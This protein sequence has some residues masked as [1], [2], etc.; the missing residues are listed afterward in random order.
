MTRHRRTA[1]LALVAGLVAGG[2][3]AGC[4]MPG[5]GEKELRYE[6]YQDAPQ[7][8]DRD[9]VPSSFIPTDAENLRIR[10]VTD[11]PGAI[12]GYESPSAPIGDDCRPASLADD[13]LLTARWW[14]DDV[15][16][17]GLICGDWQIFEQ[18]GTTF[19]FR[20]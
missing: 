14:P 1:V 2:T 9:L 16:A 6:V 19:A 7:R 20:R 8:G 11:G 5:G 4:A 10:V 3:L 12:V 17:E 15:P 18:D 13:P